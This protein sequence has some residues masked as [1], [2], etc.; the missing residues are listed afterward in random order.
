[1][2]EMLKD[3]IPGVG[4]EVGFGLLAGFVAGY[5]WKKIAKLAALALGLLF[6]A[7]QY[8]AYKNLISVNWPEI[9]RIAQSF[10][11]ETSQIQ[12]GWQAIL[13]ANLPF[14]GTFLVG[15]VLGFKKG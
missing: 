12:S 11:Q 10:Y 9:E 5:T 15:F 1:M 3:L 2:F 6:F 4:S 7:L 14:A 8:L 13:T